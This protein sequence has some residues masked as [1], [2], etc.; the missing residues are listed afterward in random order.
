[1]SEKFPKPRSLGENVNAELDLSSYS[2]KADLKN[3]TDVDTSQFAKKVGLASLKSETDK[4]DISKLETS[5]VNLK[6]NK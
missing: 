5:P 3:A 4:L 1:M 6:K 2:I